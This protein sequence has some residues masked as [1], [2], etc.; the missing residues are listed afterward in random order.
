MNIPLR[1]IRLDEIEISQHLDL[2]R[3]D[4][5]WYWRKYTTQKGYSFGKTNQLIKNFRIPVADTHRLSY[6][7]KAI[8]QIANEFVQAAND[9]KYQNYT[10]IPIPTSKEEIIQVMMSVY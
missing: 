3:T 2:D 9:S 7:Q 1:I 4:E 10:F 5:C 8:E 6:K